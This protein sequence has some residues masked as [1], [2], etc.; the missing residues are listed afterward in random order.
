MLFSVP[1]VILV[2]V[3]GMAWL[4]SLSGKKQ[5][6]RILGWLFLSFVF[7]IDPAKQAWGNL[8]HPNMHENIRPVIQYIQ[9]H[10]LENDQVYLYYGAESAYRYY[11]PKFNLVSLTTINGISSRT[12]PEKYQQDLMQLT[13]KGRVWIVFSHIYNSDKGSESDIFLKLLDKMG[14]QLDKTISDGASAYL[15]DL[16]P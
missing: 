12:D 14:R 13:G 1:F 4:I 16:T 7:L 11:A 2:M 9:I 8:I 3:N 5:G 10:H 15:Y 6:I